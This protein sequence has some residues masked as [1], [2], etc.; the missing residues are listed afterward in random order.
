MKQA[1]FFAD[2]ISAFSITITVLVIICMTGAFSLLFWLY[3]HNKRRIV[4][5][6]GEDAELGDY[7]EKEFVKFRLK[8]N[9]SALPE[10]FIAYKRKQ[11]K[12]L[13]IITDVAY[14]CVM[15]VILGIG[16]FALA[17]RA[18]GHQLYLGDTA[19]LAIQTGSM[20]KKNSG[21]PKYNELPD[22]QIA[23]HALIGIRKVEEQELQLYDIIAF[24]YESTIYVHRIVQIIEAK[25]QRFYVTQGDSNTG[26]FPFETELVIDQIIGKYNGTQSLGWGIFFTYLESEAG[27]IAI[28]FAICLLLVIDFSEVYLSKSYKKRMEYIVHELYGITELPDKKGG[29]D[30]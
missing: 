18:S 5:L 25:D 29:N 13:R 10:E 6:G 26:S 4:E 8:K 30:V 21:H 17:F 7:I 2:S 23:Q 27:I 9:E 11:S 16:C 1:Q 22:N 19:Y 28:I 24:R 3:C 20:S 15:L 12:I 14:G